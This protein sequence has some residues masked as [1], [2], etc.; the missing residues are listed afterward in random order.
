M[1]K[2]AWSV[3]GLV[4]VVL[5]AAANWKSYVSGVQRERTRWEAKTAR[6]EAMAR[7]HEQRMIA[8]KHEAEVK[9]E[10][11]KKR[12]ARAAAGAQSELDGLRNALGERQVAADSSACP[13][14]DAG[15]RLEQ[16]L[17][18]Y[19]AGALVNLAAEAD[20]LEATVVGLQG[21]VKNVCQA[22]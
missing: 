22:R 9:Y 21:Y 5:F 11:L 14:A 6:A 17:L 12:S 1:S 15:A 2:Y 8:A 4:L 20:R 18:G 13:R 19:C 7:E 16:E 3:A 10:Q